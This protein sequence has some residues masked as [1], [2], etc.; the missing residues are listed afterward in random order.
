LRRIGVLAPFRAIGF[1]KNPPSHREVHFEDPTEAAEAVLL[2]DLLMRILD[3]LEE[4]RSKGPQSGYTPTV[5]P[6]V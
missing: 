2:A 4:E 5:L 3:H 1:I 6:K